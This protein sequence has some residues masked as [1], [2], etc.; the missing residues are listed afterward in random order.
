MPYSGEEGLTRR[1]QNAAS[2]SLSV[3]VGCR[4]VG[5]GMDRDPSLYNTL[6]GDDQTKL[7]QTGCQKLSKHLFREPK[8]TKPT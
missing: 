6:V 2:Y 8:F 5:D 3:V 4:R 1:R 7:T